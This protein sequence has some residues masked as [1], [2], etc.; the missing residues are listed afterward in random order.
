MTCACGKPRRISGQSDKCAECARQIRRE[1]QAVSK[2]IWKHVK[3]TT[4]RRAA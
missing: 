3:A 4:Y 2:A 1:T